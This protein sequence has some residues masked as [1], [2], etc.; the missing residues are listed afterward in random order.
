MQVPGTEVTPEQT[1]AVSRVVAGAMILGLVAFAVVV[2]LITDPGEGGP[3]SDVLLVIAASVLDVGLVTS[4][5]VATVLAGLQRNKH[6]L[7]EAD[8][9]KAFFTAT[10]IRSAALEGPG[11]L[12]LALYMTTGNRLL[13]G[14]AAVAGLMMLAQFPTRGAFERFRARVRGSTQSGGFEPR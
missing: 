8:L 3:E 10:V 1:L 12:G 9:A 4:V 13:L 2:L 5:H 11:F 6:A 7:D 14:G